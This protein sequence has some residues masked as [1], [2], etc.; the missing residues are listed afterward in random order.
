MIIFA[1]TVDINN[2]PSE[3]WS[4]TE[5]KMRKRAKSLP[6]YRNKE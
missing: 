3:F 2:D 1:R 5:Y 4:E 6:G